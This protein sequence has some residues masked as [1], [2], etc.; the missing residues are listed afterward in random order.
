MS[1]FSLAV[2]RQPRGHSPVPPHAVMRWPLRTSATMASSAPGSCSSATWQSPPRHCRPQSQCCQTWSQQWVL[3]RDGHQGD[4]RVATCIPG[5]L[6][7]SVYQIQALVRNSNYPFS[8]VL[9]LLVQVTH[10][11]SASHGSW[12]TNLLFLGLGCTD[13]LAR[14]TRS[15]HLLSSGSLLLSSLGASS[16]SFM[17]VS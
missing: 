16:V 15:H 2:E 10:S 17:L 12:L 9:L 13:A 7:P 3:G 4:A 6:L 5:L 8:F 14:P 1:V 11:G